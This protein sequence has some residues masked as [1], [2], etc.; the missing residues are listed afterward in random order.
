MEITA[1]VDD[2][3]KAVAFHDAEKDRADLYNE[4]AKAAVETLKNMGLRPDA[5]KSAMKLRKLKPHELHSWLKSF[6]FMVAALDL[7]AQYD[8]E[9]AIDGLRPKPG[10]GISAVE[11]T[12]MEGNGVR[13]DQEG[14]ATS[15]GNRPRARG[16]RRHYDA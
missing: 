9:D 11:I 7:D 13:L 15:V 4:N 8:L 14:N 12:D 16:R 10:S 5:V 2:V 6:E 1:T 3:K